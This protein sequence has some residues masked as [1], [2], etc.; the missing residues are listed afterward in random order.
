MYNCRRV[1]TPLRMGRRSNEKCAR[2]G[3]RRS[4]CLS[5]SL[6]L[7]ASTTYLTQT[8]HMRL[9]VFISFTFH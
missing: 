5:L 3:R 4:L 8:F 9:N 6:S 7:C 2:Y 1:Q